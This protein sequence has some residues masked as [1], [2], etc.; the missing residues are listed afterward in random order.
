MKISA[1]A[2]T[3]NRKK[4]LLECLNA[5]NSQTYPL[6]AIFIVDGPS[7]D[8]TPEALLEQGY[9]KELPPKISDASWETENL[10]YS[11]VN[12]NLIKV[13]YIRL[14]KDV[15]GAGG[16]HEGVKKAYERGY[17]W[18]WLMDDDAEPKEDA[19]EKLIKYINLPNAVGLA[20]LKVNNNEDVLYHHR[21]YFYFEDIFKHIV[22]PI[23]DSDY[24]NREFLE[25]DHASFVGILV[26]SNAIKK[27]GFPDKQ[28]FIHFDDVEYSIRLR[29]IGKIYLIPDSIIVHKE[30]LKSSNSIEKGFFGRKSHRIQYN[31]LW[32]IYYGTRNLIYLGRKYS[33]NKPKF[34][35]G[36]LRRYIL[37]VG[38]IVLFDNHKLK[39]IIFLTSAYLDGLR[40]IFDN[41]KPKRILYGGG[42]K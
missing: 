24:E 26:N 37:S 19:L 2:V 15:G 34:I 36:L 5:L 20:C 1:V 10:I 31:K 13:Y 39:R 7:T 8:G 3:F 18:I 27:I 41:E 42:K 30:N 40:N 11:P 25:I 17:D 23:E 9:I 32:K 16:F 12:S 21:G 28:F 33:K 4:L 38:A 35:V 6:D 22:K 29:S 14:Y